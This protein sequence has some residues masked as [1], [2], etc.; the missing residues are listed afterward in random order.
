MGNLLSLTGFP[1]THLARPKAGL[2]IQNQSHLRISMTDQARLENQMTFFL[3]FA[4]L[5]A[6]GRP[7]SESEQRKRPSDSRVSRA[8]VLEGI[9]IRS[10]LLRHSGRTL[11]TETIG[12]PRCFQAATILACPHDAANQIAPCR[13]HEWSERSPQVSHSQ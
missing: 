3:P 1:A 4:C 12:T 7:R 10:G 9:G 13:P 5:L 11:P 8:M 2:T 6:M